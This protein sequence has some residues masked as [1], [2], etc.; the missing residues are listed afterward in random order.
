MR[1]A[2]HSSAKYRKLSA[3]H[4]QHY[5]VFKQQLAAHRQVQRASQQASSIGDRYRERQW[6]MVLFQNAQA[7]RHPQF[8]DRY[9]CRSYEQRRKKMA[10]LTLLKA[11]CQVRCTLT[12]QRCSG[13]AAVDTI[14]KWLLAHLTIISTT[15]TCIYYLF[16]LFFFVV[17]R[18]YYASMN[19]YYSTFV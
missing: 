17:R 12:Q 8:A 10:V 4:Q 11:T 7:C 15:S 5:Q 18:T 6:C 14:F 16:I 19:L 1:D 2:V 3:G 9:F 13:T